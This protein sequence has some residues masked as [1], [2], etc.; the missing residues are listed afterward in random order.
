MTWAVEL[1]Y[2]R[3]EMSS[4]CW[5][6]EIIEVYAGCFLKKIA[7]LKSAYF[8]LFFT[9]STSCF[10][11]GLCL[12]ICASRIFL[13]IQLCLQSKLLQISHNT[14]SKS[15]SVFFQTSQRQ[16]SC[17]VMESYNAHVSCH[18]FL[19]TSLSLNLQVFWSYPLH[20]SNEPSLR[21]YT[22]PVAPTGL[23]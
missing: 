19:D 1:A 16:T 6:V 7:P 14:H 21:P 11:L 15:A 8:I 23:F 20:S 13:I 10:G 12:Y 18:L 3:F 4:M 17:K 9:I 22:E 5:T 2:F